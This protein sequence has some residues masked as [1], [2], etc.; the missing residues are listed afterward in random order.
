MLISMQNCKSIFATCYF[1]NQLLLCN[2]YRDGL[3]YNVLLE[4]CND[5]V[6]FKRSKR[7][8]EGI[9]LHYTFQEEVQFP[10]FIVRT[11]YFLIY[12]GE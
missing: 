3:H 12:C 5:D 9:V 7:V 2:V 11:V 6:S 1:F 8:N 4:K 10:R